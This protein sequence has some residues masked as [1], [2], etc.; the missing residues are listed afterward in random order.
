M[1]LGIRVGQV[2]IRSASTKLMER[3][4]RSLLPSIRTQET[5]AKGAPSWYL[6]RRHDGGR[7]EP[8]HDLRP[9]G[10]RHLRHRVQDSRRRGSSDL[11]PRSEVSVI[12]Y[13]QEPMPYGLFVPD[14]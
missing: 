4:L 2:E 13:F 9:E 1:C 10:R 6:R 14:A 3:R 8:D 12:R 5:V 11:D 7:Q